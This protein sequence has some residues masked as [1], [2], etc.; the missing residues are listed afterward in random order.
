M[1]YQLFGNSGLRVFF[2]CLGI[3]IFGKDWGWGFIVV[4]SKDI[5]DIFLE[6][7][8]NFIDIVDVYMEG[9]SEIIFGELIQ[10]E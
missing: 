5:F 1:Y 6:V 3:M 2:L 10:V 9:S 7:G 4:E 8:G